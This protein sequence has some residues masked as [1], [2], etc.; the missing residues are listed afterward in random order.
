MVIYSFVDKNR[1]I[2]L[3]LEGTDRIFYLRCHNENSYNDW[4]TKLKFS[5]ERSTGFMKKLSAKM[6][7]N[8]FNTSYDFWRIFRITEEGLNF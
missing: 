3:Q 4:K 7:V 2:N 8:D 5:I 1:Y 6:Y